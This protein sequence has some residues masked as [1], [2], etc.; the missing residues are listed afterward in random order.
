MA[1]LL[2]IALGVLI[3]LHDNPLSWVDHSVLD[4]MVAHRSSTATSVFAAVTN[5]FGPVWVAA[6]TA[7]SAVAFVL[8]DRSAIRGVTVIATVALA[9]C[10]G[11]VFK[12]TFD[13][14]RPPFVDQAGTHE[15]SQSFPSGHVTG[16]TALLLAVAVTATVASSRV[17]RSVAIAVAL[18]MSVFAALT[19]LYLGV[20]WFSDVVAAVVLATAVALV[21]PS[22]VATMLGFLE[23]NAPERLRSYLATA[24]D[25]G[26]SSDQE[27]E[28]TQSA[29][30]TS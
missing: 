18:T 19:R 28:G 7:I 21:V 14:T 4:W 10:L 30:V 9:G 27:R 13:R 17:Q 11:A 5:L 22:L 8:S 25:G 29:P 3:T 24:S 1:L 23:A 15:A 20:H 6:A 26:R 12:V 16:T 2:V